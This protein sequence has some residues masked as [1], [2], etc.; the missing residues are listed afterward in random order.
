MS[1]KINGLHVVLD[2][3]RSIEIPAFV[4][5]VEVAAIC[6]HMDKRDDVPEAPEAPATIYPHTLRELL[7]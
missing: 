1:N 4:E 6:A 2:G 5:T 3:E 7:S